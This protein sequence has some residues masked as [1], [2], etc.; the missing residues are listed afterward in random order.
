MLHGV[1]KRPRLE[2]RINQEVRIEAVELKAVQGNVSYKSVYVFIICIVLSVYLH[3]PVESVAT[4]GHS[5]AQLETPPRAGMKM[6][7]HV[8]DFFWLC[9]LCECKGKLSDKASIGWMFV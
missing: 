7:C 6:R 8:L 4:Q 9:Q 2:V 3:L 1:S 5:A